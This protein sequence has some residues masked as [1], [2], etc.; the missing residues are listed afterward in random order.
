MTCETLYWVEWINDFGPQVDGP[1]LYAEARRY[2]DMLE[3]CSNT[4]SIGLAEAT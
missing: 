3:T 1:F 2:A 4:H